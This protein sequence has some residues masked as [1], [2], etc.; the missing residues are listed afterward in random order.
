MTSKIPGKPLQ[1][2][3]ASNSCQKKILSQGTCEDHIRPSVCPHCEMGKGRGGPIKGFRG[4]WW[5][6][7]WAGRRDLPPP[8]APP[9]PHPGPSAGTWKSQRCL[10]LAL[11]NEHPSPQLQREQA[12]LCQAYKLHGFPNV[13]RAC[14]LGINLKSSIALLIRAEDTGAF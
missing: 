8:P 9:D 10:S 12:G 6:L 7:S 4:S 13:F 2:H 3:L 11:F 1:L 5:P 14:T